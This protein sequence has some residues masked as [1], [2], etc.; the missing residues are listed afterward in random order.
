M[1]SFLLLVNGLLTLIGLATIGVGVWMYNSNIIALSG[2]EFATIGV[3][4]GAF[5]FMV[6][7][8]GFLS[9]CKQWVC[10]LC[11]FAFVLFLIVCAEVTG[12]IFYLTIDGKM[13]SFFRDRW[14]G[15]SAESQESFQEQFHCCGWDESAPSTDC[16]DGVEPDDYCWNA[17]E[18]EIV[19]QQKT[20]M[21]VMIGIAGLEIIMLVFTI[22]L[23]C[24]VRALK[25]NSEPGAYGV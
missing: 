4:F 10:G 12:V 19:S 24:K 22:C 11:F 13:E 3:C 15:L 20:V 18:N 1:Q 5:V 14:E 6:G 8:C 9:A 25:E 17:M 2:N 23:I 21:Y 7:L 16:P